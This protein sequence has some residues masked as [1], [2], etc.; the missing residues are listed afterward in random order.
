[1]I[2]EME[3]MYVRQMQTHQFTDAKEIFLFGL[4]TGAAHETNTWKNRVRSMLDEVKADY[5][6][7]DVILEQMEEWL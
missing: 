4:R 5:I 3:E 1:M 7:V 6:S 2:K